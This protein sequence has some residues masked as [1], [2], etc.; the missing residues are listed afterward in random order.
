VDPESEEGAVISHQSAAELWGFK[1]RSTGPIHVTLPSAG[2]RRRRKGIRIHRSRTLGPGCTALIVGVRATTPP[3]TL[4]DLKRTLDEDAHRRATRRA[5]DLGLVEPNGAH[6]PDLAR[7][8]L[9]RRFLALCRR[10]RLPK[11]E[12]N[13]RLG[14]YEVDFLWREQDLIVELDGYEFHRDREAFERDRARDAD[15]QSQGFRVLRFTWRRLTRSRG[16]VARMVREV[17]AA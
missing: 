14:R 16:E 6:D 10:H 12:V 15:L 5:L 2:G 7:S 4:R 9:E 13:A 3:R 1:A 8:E 11:P 17:L